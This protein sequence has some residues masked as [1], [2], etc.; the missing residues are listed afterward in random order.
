MVSFFYIF[1]SI[2]IWNELY[3][4]LNRNRLYDKNVKNDILI[5]SNIDIFFYFT[6]FIMWMFIALGIFLNTTMFSIILAIKI[7]K[8]LI[9]H[10]NKKYFIIYDTI[11][12][13]LTSIVFLIIIILYF[14][15]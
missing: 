1:L 8:F 6:R 5:L 2:F 11:S 13:V 4:L 9:Y 7:I 3:Y 12:P 14:I 15:N 10:I